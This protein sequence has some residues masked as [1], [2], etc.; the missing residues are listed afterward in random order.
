MGSVYQNSYLTLAGASS[1]QST[2]GLF[3][4][5]PKLEISGKNV[6]GPYHIYARRE[7]N[8][9][10]Q[11]FPLLKRG[12]VTQETMLAPRTLFCGEQELVWYC[13][14][15]SACQCSAQDNDEAFYSINTKL[16]RINELQKFLNGPKLVKMWYDIVDVYST[17]CLTYPSDKL[18]AIDGIASYMQGLRNCEYLAGLWA[19]SLALDLL[20]SVDTLGRSSKRRVQTDPPPA[21]TKWTSKNWMFPTWSWSSIEGRVVYD[22]VEHLSEIMHHRVFS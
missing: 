16:P 3:F 8:H 9:H 19:D 10:A 6:D 2:D 20:W 5:S 1:S 17:T 11:S 4:Q 7:I 22:W 14:T 21:K 12:W 18:V 13:R 15:S